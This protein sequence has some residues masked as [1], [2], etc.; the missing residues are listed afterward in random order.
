MSGKAYWNPVRRSDM[1]EFSSK[2]DW[3]CVFNDLHFT[4]LLDASPLIVWSS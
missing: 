1:P 4:N 2:L 3:K